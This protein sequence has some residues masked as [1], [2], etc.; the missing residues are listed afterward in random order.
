MALGCNGVNRL[1]TTTPHISLS[2]IHALHDA[3]FEAMT[4][5]VLV[6]DQQGVIL[7]C[8]PAFHQRLGYSREDLVGTPVAELDPPE[9]SR[10]VPER[11]KTIMREGQATFETAHYHKDG[12]VMPVELCAR[13]VEINGEI[14]LFS[15]VRDIT[16]RRRLEESLREGFEMYQ[17]AINTSALGFWVTDTQG[18]FLEVNDAYAQLSGYSREEL[19]CMSIPD[20]EAREE[21]QE[22]AAHI[23]EIMQSGYARFRTAHRKKDGHVWPAGIVTSFS[24]IQGGR[25]FVFI[26][27]LSE[28][29]TQEG[30]LELASLVFENM[31]QAV[32]ITDADNRIVSINPATVL[33]TGY[34]LEELRGRNPNIFASGRHDDSFYKELWSTLN[35]TGHWEGEIWDR[36]KDGVAYA[37]WLSINAIRD[38]HG[39]VYQ[40]VSVFSDITERKK[41]EE[42]IWKQANFDA[43]TGLPNRHLMHEHLEQEIRKAQRTGRQLA[44]LFIDLDRFKEVND[45]FGHSKGDALLVMA[46]RRITAHVRETD[47]VARLGGDEFTVILPDFDGRSHLERITQNLVEEL[48][49]PYDLG[50]GELGYVSASIGITLY[51]DDSRD[52]QGLLKHA[53]QAMYVAKAD[54]RNR[55][56]YFTPSMQDEAREKQALTGDLRQ[57]LA[58]QQM[59][60][61]YQPIVNL[62]T[63]EIVKAEALLRWNH[64]VRGMIPP[65]TFIPIAEDSGLIHE[66]GAWVFQQAIDFIEH[67]HQHLGLTIQISVNKSPL[68][69]EKLAGN[70]WTERLRELGL[71][72]NSITVEI[73]ESSLL[74]K[75]PR[76]KQRLIDYRNTGVEVSIDDFGTGFSALSYLHQFDVD[77]LKIDRSFV[78]DLDENMAHTALTEAI[79]VMAHKLG[80]RTVAEGVETELQRDLLKKFGCDYAQGY[81][82][83]RPIPAGEFEQLLKKG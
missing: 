55:F 10:M 54:G 12:T 75:S 38:Q 62:G 60:V 35:N 7:D 73:T 68:Q 14:V 69:F 17:T 72:G 19:L 80:I 39:E 76:V 24:H 64:P 67:L 15:I 79:I 70:R 82:Y 52:L 81:L 16:E 40:Y 20:I 44:V 77:Y 33:I 53:D 32:V 57:A 59:E 48:S 31:D 51:P 13:F 66:I 56:G 61:Y 18:R 37:K 50:E 9:F 49:E 41:T 71:P 1:S 45:T 5:G 26:E 4:D 8:N 21:P 11:I 58:F 34:T 78:S 43:L 29:V 3:L 25:F 65:L 36:R 23:A 42:L 28:K 47:T 30:R 83:S 6:I 46:A 74:S 27:D 22:T 63:G 2:S